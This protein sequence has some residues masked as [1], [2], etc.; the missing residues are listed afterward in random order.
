MLGWNGNNP[1][2]QGENSTMTGILLID[3]SPDWTSHDVVAKLRRLCK[4]RRIGHAGTLDP[5]A[6]G[7]LV[8]CIG[9]ATRG[10]EFAQAEE[11]TYITRLQLGLTTDTQD[12]TGRIL[13]QCDSQIS[14]ADLEEVL[15]K[16]QG[17]ISQLPPMYSA[18]K[19]KGQK[20]Y[21]LARQ[22]IEIEREPRR[23]TIRNISILGQT[24]NG[25]D[26]EI[27]CSKGTYIRTL[28]H[29]IGAALGRGGAMAALRRT[30]IGQFSLENAHTMEALESEENIGQFLHP[31]D[32]LFSA[33][34]ALALDAIREKGLKNGQTLDMPRGEP[35]LYRVYSQT[36]E[37]LAFG[38]IIKESQFKLTV[39]KS[40]FTPNP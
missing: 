30:R 40:F 37:F 39:K 17:E 18:I 10:V 29:D 13:S 3:K 38:E 22:G 9:R 2:L 34:P 26:L 8:V 27:T 14:Q 6:T 4:E 11:K 7:L 24:E 28:C 32:N 25:F 1:L 31:V 36:G 16:F 12:T 23:V 35:G 15:P 5:M 33:Y 20:L 19:I 21:Q